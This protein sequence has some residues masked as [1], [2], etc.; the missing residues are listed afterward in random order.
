MNL[1]L[2]FTDLQGVVK[3]WVFIWIIH[4][5]W[6]YGFEHVSIQY[7][8]KKGV[9]V[10]WIS[11][12][13]QPVTH[14]CIH[15]IQ[16]K[17]YILLN[18]NFKDFFRKQMNMNA[19]QNIFIFVSVHC[20]WQWVC[21]WNSVQVF[22]LWQRNWFSLQMDRKSSEIC[23]VVW[24]TFTENHSAYC[25]LREHQVIHSKKPKWLNAGLVTLKRSAII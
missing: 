17:I 21:L 9:Q 1:S 13:F 20:W 19:H 2:T 25:K 22:H 15:E 10:T 23:D 24:E 14:S 12:H 4:G 16:Q 18:S 5:N 6:C 3:K 11:W 8:A 7:F